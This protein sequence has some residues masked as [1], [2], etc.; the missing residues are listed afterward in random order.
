[1]FYSFF[2][3]K[4]QINKL[5]FTPLTIKQVTKA[6]QD[7]I[8][9]I[10]QSKKKIKKIYMLR[11]LIENLGLIYVDVDKSSYGKILEL[12]QNE[13]IYAPNTTDEYLY[14]GV[15]YRYVKSDYKKSMVY[16]ER[17]AAKG[18]VVATNGL[19]HIYETHL[20]DPCMAI[21]YFKQSVVLSEND[22][23]R[24]RAR[25]IIGLA[26]F[27]ER[28]KDYEKAL[29]WYEQAIKID[30]TGL[31]SYDLADMYYKIKN[32]DMA[33]LYYEKAITCGHKRALYDL[34]KLFVEQNKNYE[35][36]KELCI[37]STKLGN[38]KAIVFLIQS[39]QKREQHEEAF[40]LGYEYESILPVDDRTKLL[41][42]LRYPISPTNKIAIY[43]ILEIIELPTHIQTHGHI[44]RIMQDVF[45]HRQELMCKLIYHFKKAQPDGNVK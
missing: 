39:L 6:Q 4:N 13:I 35:K 21:Q 14:L 1:M 23:H 12:F 15:F 7:K 45:W 26:R 31:A 20:K 37:Q 30:C 17:A 9:F 8:D 28:Q 5:I 27:Y 24:A 11:E 22:D 42:G 29:S 32:F 43:K 33:I 3:V 18:S 16:Y 41:N 10:I 40:I 19:A 2:V 25:A 38:S 44:L 36:A 34:A